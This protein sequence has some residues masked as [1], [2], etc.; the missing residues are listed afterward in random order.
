M[1]KFWNFFGLCF[2]A[3]GTI[4]GFGNAMMNRSYFIASCVIILAILAFPEAKK[5]FKDMMN[6]E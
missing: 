6:M 3:V 5:M 4:G 2:Y 1:K